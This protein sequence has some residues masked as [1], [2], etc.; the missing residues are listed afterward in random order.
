M[1]LFRSGVRY[2]IRLPS[3]SQ[4]RSSERKYTL[5]LW[6]LQ[7]MG[8]SSRAMRETMS[9]WISFQMSHIVLISITNLISLLRAMRIMDKRLFIS[10]LICGQ[11]F[12][13]FLMQESNSCPVFWLFKKT[14][15]AR[16]LSHLLLLMSILNNTRILIL[17]CCSLIW[18]FCKQKTKLFLSNRISCIL[19]RF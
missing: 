9:L 17:L 1:R 15:L 11:M 12:S 13:R 2:M 16:P 3:K 18:W 7:N 10:S 5:C 6:A 14:L 8:C 19:A 4:R